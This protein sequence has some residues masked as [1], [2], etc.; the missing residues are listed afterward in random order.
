[1]GA[2]RVIDEPAP[3]VD[4][5]VPPGRCGLGWVDAAVAVAL[6]LLALFVRRHSY[7]TDGLWLDDAWVGVSARAPLSD[8]L[9]VSWN[10]PGFTA[11]LQV[12]N[13]V[14]HIH[15]ITRQNAKRAAEL[16]ESVAGLLRQSQALRAQIALFKR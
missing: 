9:S 16:R 15:T 11:M 8:L 6:G 4:G 13:A 5:A 3:S 10:H 1:M 2:R 7:P 14:E 12:V